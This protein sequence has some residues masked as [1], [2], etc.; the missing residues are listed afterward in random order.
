[1]L[2]VPGVAAPAAAGAERTS[3][4]TAAA[5][6]AQRPGSRHRKDAKDAK[7][8]IEKCNGESGKAL[9]EALPPSCSTEAQPLR[10]RVFAVQKTLAALVVGVALCGDTAAAVVGD[11]LHIA[12]I[13]VGVAAVEDAAG[14]GGDWTQLTILGLSGCCSDVRCA[15]FRWVFAQIAL[16]FVVSMTKCLKRS[17]CLLFGTSLRIPIISL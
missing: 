11:L 5:Q 12:D 4:L 3:A 17:K 13:V 15:S 14:R 1:V 10:L 16:K 6:R 2:A 7:V 8:G 9:L